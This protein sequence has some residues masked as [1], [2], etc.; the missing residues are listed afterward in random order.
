MLTTNVST[1]ASLELTI[2]EVPT[3]RFALATCRE[4]VMLHLSWSAPNADIVEIAGS[5]LG[6]EAYSLGRRHIV[7]FYE[8]RA[9]QADSEAAIPIKELA[10]RVSGANDCPLHVCC[11]VLAWAHWCLGFSCTAID[12]TAVNSLDSASCRSEQGRVP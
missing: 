7:G 9:G 10:V 5:N 3:G 2:D 12:M 6:T 1:V 8:W 11:V 4:G